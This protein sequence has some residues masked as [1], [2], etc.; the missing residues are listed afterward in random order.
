VEET[1]MLVINSLELYSS[2]WVT[3]CLIMVVGVIL[4][5]WTIAQDKT[6]MGMAQEIRYDLRYLAIGFLLVIGGI[7]SLIPITVCVVLWVLDIIDG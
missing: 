1:G 3:N 4:V 6:S 7:M 5:L 2:A